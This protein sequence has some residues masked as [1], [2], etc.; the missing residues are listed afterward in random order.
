MKKQNQNKTKKLGKSSQHEMCSVNETP[1]CYDLFFS[2]KKKIPSAAFCACFFLRLTMHGSAVR[3]QADRKRNVLGIQHGTEPCCAWVLVLFLLLTCLQNI[4]NP[5]LKIS[6]SCKIVTVV[7]PLLSN[8]MR[9]GKMLQNNY[10][11]IDTEVNTKFQPW[12][13]KYPSKVL[14]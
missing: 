4:I 7:C 1:L 3:E 11:K 6:C 2:H 8:N 13:G 5:S 14:S 12:D 10:R 9:I